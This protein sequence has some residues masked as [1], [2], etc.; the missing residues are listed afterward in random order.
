MCRQCLIA[1]LGGK[2]RHHERHRSSLG[3]MRSMDGGEIR[4]ARSR[5]DCSPHRRRSELAGRSRGRTNARDGMLSSMTGYGDTA[6]PSVRERGR[7]AEPP[8]AGI[9]TVAVIAIR[10]PC[11]ILPVRAHRPLQW[12]DLAEDRPD[13]SIAYGATAAS[14]LFRRLRRHS[15]RDKESS[16]LCCQAPSGAPSIASGLS[17]AIM[18]PQMG[19]GSR[20]RSG[21]GHGD[22]RHLQE[23]RTSPNRFTSVR[24]QGGVVPPASAPP[25]ASASSGRAE[26]ARPPPGETPQ[27]R[28]ITPP[29]P[30]RGR[31]HLAPSLDDPS[32]TAPIFA[33]PSTTRDG[34]GQPIWS[35]PSRRNAD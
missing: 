11:E 6:R 5:P 27:S 32:F 34:E 24:C 33:N 4:G 10:S 30:T 31:D 20:Q 8:L 28:S 22:H 29:G 17:V 25:R 12:P 13:A 23:V 21:E 14:K 19:A 2:G 18:R 16:P 15:S 3:A 9:L 35:C 1:G 26:I 7:W